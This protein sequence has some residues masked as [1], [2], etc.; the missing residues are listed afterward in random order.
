MVDVSVAPVGEDVAIQQQDFLAEVEGRT[1]LD[2]FRATVDAHRD[3]PAL[4]AQRADG[5]FRTR[6]WGEYEDEASRVAMAL[7]RLGVAHGD[8]VALMVTNR[9][10]HVIADVGT[11][12]AGATPVSVYNTLAPEQVAYVA[13]NCD[14]KVA[15][16]EDAAFLATWQEVRDQLPSLE[17]IVVLEPAGVDT[18]TPDVTTYEQ[19]LADGAQAL[20][21]GRGEL[22]NAWRSVSPDDPLTLIYTS[23]TTGPPK[24]VIL[25]HRNLLFQ[26]VVTQRMLDVEPGQRGVSYLPLAHIAERMTSHYL[27]IRFATTVYYAAEVAQLLPTLLEA[28]PHALMAVPRVWEKMHAALRAGIDAEEDE[29]RRKVAQKAIAVGTEAVGLEMRGEKVPVRLRLQ[30]RL[31]DKLVFSKIREKL[32]LDQLRYSLSGAAPISADLLVFFKAIGIE[33]LEVYGMTEST[34][35]ITANRPGRVRIGTVGEPVPG[36]E[37][38]LA[39]DGEVLARGPHI[40]PGYWRREDATAEAID[41]DGWLHTGDL[42]T[43]EDGYLRI[44][45]R[46]KEL[47][48]TAGGKNLSPNNIEETIKQQSILIGQLC[49]IG[50]DRPFIGALIVLD[51]EM[52]PLW[53]YQNDVPFTT[54]EA[55]AAEPK[56]IAEVERAVE[57]GNRHLARVEQVRQWAL[58]PTEWTAESEELTPSLKLKRAVIHDKYADAIDELYQR[59]A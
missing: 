17:H 21:G 19:L 58:V 10:E 52:L 53:C 29:R 42:G 12:L 15:I 22:E 46:K 35:V 57:A 47:I 1:L 49:A 5:S 34:A 6:T 30:H 20:A 3:Q 18:S 4:V 16:V 54:V 24:G 14:A 7:R 39:E 2:V 50:D 55:A 27:A 31:F 32:G 25:T 36:T 23:G 37:L 41:A 28:R 48:I 8:F 56:V 26:L 13:G 9:P 45:G 38:R 59:R 44:V 11:L 43:M 51:A 40:T 33:I